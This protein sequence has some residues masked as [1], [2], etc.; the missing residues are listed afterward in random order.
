[1]ATVWFEGIEELTKLSVDLA[2]SAPKARLMAKMALNKTAADIQR[3]AMAT[4][5]VDTGTLKNSIS[6]TTATVVNLEVEIGP[7]ANYG[8]YIEYGTSRMDPQ[9][10]MGPAFDK[11][12]PAF[13]AAMEQIAAAPPI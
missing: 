12:V 9:P 7:T 13:E 5:P 11:Y 4:V 8:T 3:E 10:F 1:V 2:T 6:R